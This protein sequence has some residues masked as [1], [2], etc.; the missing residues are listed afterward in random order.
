MF[1]KYIF[2]VQRIVLAI[3]RSY[4]IAIMFRFIL[5]FNEA[6]KVFIKRRGRR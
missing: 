6:D 1:I 2:Y 3:V 5:F 4:K